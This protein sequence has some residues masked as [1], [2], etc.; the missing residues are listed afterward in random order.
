MSISLKVVSIALTFCASF[1]RWA[2]RSRMRFILTLCSV[3][4]PLISDVGS[5]GGSLTV[6]ASS[7]W[8]WRIAATGM[9]DIGADGGGGAGRGGGGGGA[10][11]AAA[12][13]GGG[14]AA[15][16]VGGGGGGAAAAAG[17]ASAFLAPPGPKIN[18]NEI[19]T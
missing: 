2:I 6:A 16:G 11:A 19:F 4:V 13:G 10:A 9:E 1:S 17:L 18:I 7:V 14:A 15:A 5:A 8:A 3:R 12:G